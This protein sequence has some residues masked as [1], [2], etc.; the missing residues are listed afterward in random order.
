MSS[1]PLP[2]D[3][4]RGRWRSPAPRSARALVVLALAVAT[5]SLLLPTASLRPRSA[6]LRPAP[7]RC[8]PLPVPRPAAPTIG[9]LLGSRSGCSPPRGGAGGGR[10]LIP[11]SP[12]PL[13]ACS[14]TASSR[15]RPVRLANEQRPDNARRRRGGVRE[16]APVR[17]TLEGKGVCEGAEPRGATFLWLHLNL[18]ALESAISGAPK[19]EP[20]VKRPFGRAPDGAAI[21]AGA[22]A[23]PNR[24]YACLH[25][26]KV[27]GTALGVPLS[28]GETLT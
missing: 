5:S 12:S 28:N 8:W 9:A 17:A 6:S 13:T 20:S 7:P 3:H 24:P 22:G 26:T 23:L 18:R 2:R 19:T 27:S 21:G 4:R 14:R 10:P 16:E 11:V 15:R 25:H 1:G